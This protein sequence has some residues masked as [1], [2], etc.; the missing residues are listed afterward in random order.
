MATQGPGRPQGPTKV[1]FPLRLYPEQLRDLKIL[2]EILDGEPPVNGL[3]VTAV[4][5]YLTHKLKNPRV[6]ASYDARVS[7]RLKVVS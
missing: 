7:S 6:R 2:H 3:I 5:R 4:A 1:P